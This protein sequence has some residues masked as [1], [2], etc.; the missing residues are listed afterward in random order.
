MELFG[1]LVM[2]VIA[3]AAIPSSSS[4]RDERRH[5]HDSYLGHSER[6]P[7]RRY[8]NEG[9]EDDFD[10]APYYPNP[11]WF[12]PNAPYG[13]PYGHHPRG[14]GF[15]ALFR[16]FF[17]GIFAMSFVV[18]GVYYR[19]AKDANPTPTAPVKEQGLGKN[20]EVPKLTLDSPKEFQRLTKPHTAYLGTT[21]SLNFREIQ[22]IYPKRGI[23]AFRDKNGQYLMCIFTDTSEELDEVVALLRY[24]EDDLKEHG[25]KLKYYKTT[26]LCSGNII[27]EKGTDI[28]FCEE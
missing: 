22:R 27:R 28:W 20:K 12:P 13:Y 8:Q 25:L 2:L 6:H 5:P 21:D 14:G 23:E 4:D 11:Y 3:L 16:A 7:R 10:H 19:Y 18:A 9:G 15:M 26:D 17:A 1:F 24:R